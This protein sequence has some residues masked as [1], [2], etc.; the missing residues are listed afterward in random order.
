[1]ADERGDDV[2][3]ALDALSE[4]IERNSEDEK[5]LQDRIRALREARRAGSDVTSALS[6]EQPPG[7]VQL[8]GRV[9]ARL[10]DSSGQLRRALARTMR[11]EGTSIPAI[12][13]L[14]G[15]THQRVSNILSRPLPNAVPGPVAHEPEEGRGRRDRPPSAGGDERE[16]AT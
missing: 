15:V 5:Q 7:T 1:M 14:F 9:L 4:A 2:V 13:R 10:M 3:G 8:L 16:R 6:L 11:A 12:A